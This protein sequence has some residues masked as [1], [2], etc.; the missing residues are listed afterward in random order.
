MAT[1]DSE[2]MLDMVLGIMTTGGA[3]NA[4]IVAIEA[5][6]I[7]AGK[8]LSPTLSS[9][10]S[11]SYHLQSWSEKIL[12]KTPAIFYGIEDVQNVSSGAHVNAKTYRVFIEIIMLDSGM[13]NDVSKRI[14]RYSRALEELFAA[15]FKAA[16]EVGTV[17]IEQVR[18]IGF[19]LELDSDEEIKVGGI[20]LTVTLT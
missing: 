12:S 10:A 14:A 6:K 15:N 17:K 9:I 2:D 20:S 11:T 7:A 8:S 1:Y 13:T 4:K 16:A 5:E 19:K 18:P 3:L